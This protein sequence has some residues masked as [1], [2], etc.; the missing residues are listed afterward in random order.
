M[1]SGLVVK[2][3]GTDPNQAI[4]IWRGSRRFG[5]IHEQ[6]EHHL[7]DLH[8]IPHQDWQIIREL[9]SNRYAMA[10]Q[11]APRQRGDV[12]NQLIQVQLLRTLE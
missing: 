1:P 5:G 12:E 10:C 6:V 11:L 4:M 9:G 2:N 3:G 7:L 8:G